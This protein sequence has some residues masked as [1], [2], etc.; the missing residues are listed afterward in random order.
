MCLTLCKPMVDILSF[1]GC[2]SQCTVVYPKSQQR[3]TKR[4]HFS[5]KQASKYNAERNAERT[6]LLRQEIVSKWKEVGVDFQ[7]YCGFIDEAGFHTQ[8]MRSR[9]WS[10][11]GDPATV[12]VYIRLEPLKRADMEKLEEEFQKPKGKKRKGD[13]LESS[14]PK[15]LKKIKKKNILENLPLKLIIRIGGL[16]N[17]KTRTELAP[18]SKSLFQAFTRPRDELHPLKDSISTIDLYKVKHMLIENR[19]YQQ[20]LVNYVLNHAPNL[21]ILFFSLIA[22][23]SMLNSSD[24]SSMSEKINC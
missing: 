13:T 20:R 5:L 4:C 7:K 6:L 24:C 3:S 11:K 2:N 15:L 8:M 10:K 14:K 19:H 17:E 21:E 18:T 23:R 22:K 12:E 16:L 1:N 9:A